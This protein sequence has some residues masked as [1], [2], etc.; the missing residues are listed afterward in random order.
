M[1]LFIILV[2]ILIIILGFIKILLRLNDYKQKH[3]FTETY[4]DQFIEFSNL[5][6]STFQKRWA[7]GTFDSEKYIW[8]TKN[9]GKI[10][11]NLGYFGRI[12]YIGPF[13]RIHIKNYE[14]VVNTLPKF[15]DGTIDAMDVNSTDDC[16]IR[17]IGVIENQIL[18]VKKK[19]K[20]PIIWFREGFE[21]V[22]S[23]PVYILSW[24]GLLTDK[25]VSKVTTNIV[26]KIIVGVGGL[27]ALLSGLVTIIQGKEETISFLKKLLH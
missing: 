20:N 25:T 17:Y 1:K 2:F 10:Q 19:L 26:Y 27:I 16:L 5:F 14:I 23:L 21:E 6:F 7:E 12:E 18:E 4:R 24:F 8:L 3:H 15:R 13:Q 22:A 11:T 9:V